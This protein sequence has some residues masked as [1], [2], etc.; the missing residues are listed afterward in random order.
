MQ[1]IDLA[2]GGVLSFLRLR[3]RLSLSAGGR[4]LTG[5]DLPFVSGFDNGRD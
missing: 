3:R 5:D 2:V 1:D 4:V